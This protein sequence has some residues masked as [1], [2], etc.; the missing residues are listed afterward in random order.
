M[1]RVKEMVAS[2]VLLLMLLSYKNCGKKSSSQ[3]EDFDICQIAQGNTG[4]C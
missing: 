3:L 4:D 1:A 2:G